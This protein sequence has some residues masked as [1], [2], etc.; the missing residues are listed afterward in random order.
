MI[1]GY[2]QKMI[3]CV[4]STFLFVIRDGQKFQDV[5]DNWQSVGDPKEQDFNGKCFCTSQHFPIGNLSVP[6]NFPGK[7]A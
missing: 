2:V 1:A 5:F 3:V 4:R 6:Q 7:R